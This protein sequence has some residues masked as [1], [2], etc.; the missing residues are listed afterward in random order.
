MKF[1][2]TLS[3][4]V[5]ISLA[6]AGFIMLTAKYGNSG[7]DPARDLLGE[8]AREHRPAWPDLDDAIA[9]PGQL[10]VLALYAVIG[11][12]FFRLRLSP[13]SRNEGKLMPLKLRQ[14]R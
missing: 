2:R 7:P 14:T 9:I 13:P 1:A 8:I 12:I 3:R 6:V 5:L 11:R 10:V 4:I